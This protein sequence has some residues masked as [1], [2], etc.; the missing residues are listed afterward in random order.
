MAKKS[1]GLKPGQKAPAS[2]QYREVGPR[3]G[4]G[5]ARLRP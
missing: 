2:G 4:G 5:A 1:S 3:G